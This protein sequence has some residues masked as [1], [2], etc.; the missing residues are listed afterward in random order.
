[1]SVIVS[2]Y[3]WLKGWQFTITFAARFAGE[4]IGLSN[5]ASPID[6]DDGS[7]T[8]GDAVPSHFQI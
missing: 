7:D 2:Q 8:M 4:Q 3:A 5:S 6:G 1:M